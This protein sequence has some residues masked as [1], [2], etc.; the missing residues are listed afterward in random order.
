MANKRDKL[1]DYLRKALWILSALALIIIVVAG[2]KYAYNRR[3][4]RK[5]AE[6][7]Q[8]IKGMHSTMSVE[9]VRQDNIQRIIAMASAASVEGLIGIQRPRWRAASE[10]LCP[11]SGS[12]TT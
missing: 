10:S 12:I 4:I 6:L 8:V 5:I 3:Y 11:S 1:S 2:I 9:S 7:E